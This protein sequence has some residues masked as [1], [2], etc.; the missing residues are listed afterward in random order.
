MTRAPAADQGTPAL[1]SGAAPVPDVHRPRPYHH[2]R[3]AEAL[4]DAAVE[5]ARVGGPGAVV[6]RE[7][8]RRVGVSATAAY[9]HFDGQTALLAA[10]KHRALGE[11]ARFMREA[12]ESVPRG[13][14]DRDRAVGR[15]GAMGAAYV[16]FSVDQRG[17]FECFCLGVPLFDGL[18]LGAEVPAF[19]LLSAMLDEMVAAGALA[20]E[21]RPGAEIPAWAAV[22]GLAVL[23]LD[24]VLAEYPGFDLDAMVRAT[25]DQLLLGLLP[26]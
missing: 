11:L 19:G 1:S 23:N 12:L 21:R 25:I 22:H 20:P 4:V 8:A 14:S 16:R 26:R 24:G 6:L 13:L 15:L 3:L 7:A 2:G 10:V 5:L 9:R 17:L 18:A